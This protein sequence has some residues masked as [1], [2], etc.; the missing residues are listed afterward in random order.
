MLFGK[1]V[2]AKPHEVDSGLHEEI[3][4]LHFENRR[5]QMGQ[6]ILKKGRTLV[7]FHL[8]TSIGPSNF[9]WYRVTE[10]VSDSLSKLLIV[11][12]ENFLVS[13]AFYGNQK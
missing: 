7:N 6:D 2:A 8:T 12:I 1:V 9:I 4:R 5:L 10:I 3:R 11:S 13:P